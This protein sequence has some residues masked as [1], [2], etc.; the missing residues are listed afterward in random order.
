MK[1]FYTKFFTNLNTVP[2]A[3]YPSNNLINEM[4]LLQ[5][6]PPLKCQVLSKNLPLCSM[7]LIST[8]TIK[9]TSTCS[10]LS[11]WGVH[12]YGLDVYHFGQFGSYT[13]WWPVLSWGTECI[14]QTKRGILHRKINK[15]KQKNP[16]MSKFIILS[17]VMATCVLNWLKWYCALWVVLSLD[18][19]DDSTEDTEV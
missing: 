14:Y 5:V 19:G 10:P 4:R 17:Q 1:N 15:T 11:A 8:M 9:P 12:S 7:L 3:V 18:S 16:A 13:S 2:L 6:D